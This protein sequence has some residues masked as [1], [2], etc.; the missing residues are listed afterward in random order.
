MPNILLELLRER[1]C[2]REELE[3]GQCARAQG[4]G[5]GIHSEICT[6]VNLY[7]Y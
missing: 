1:G 5:R 6:K 2:G 4:A 3:R 7:R